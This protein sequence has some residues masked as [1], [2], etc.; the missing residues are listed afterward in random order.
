MKAKPSLN[1]VKMLMCSNYLEVRMQ[2]P[3]HVSPGGS[4]VNFWHLLMSS[5]QE[6]SSSSWALMFLASSKTS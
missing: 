4:S 3:S 6:V 2:Q 5:K 1:Y